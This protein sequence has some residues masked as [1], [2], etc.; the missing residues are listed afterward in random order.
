MN[1]NSNS[2][3]NVTNIL[4]P[5]DIREFPKKEIN[6]SD[7][8]INYKYNKHTVNTFRDHANVYPKK[9]TA[10]ESSI[11]FYGK[12]NIENQR[13]L[14]ESRN[15]LTNINHKVS[16]QDNTRKELFRNKRYESNVKEG[17]SRSFSKSH[18]NNV[19]ITDNEINEED[20]IQKTY[21][22]PVKEYGIS[23]REKNRGNYMKVRKDLSIDNRVFNTMILREKYKPKN[24]IEQFIVNNSKSERGGTK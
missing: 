14:R 15:K 20:F 13:Q 1:P 21:Y 6:M 16:Q 8:N 17:R 11:T 4:E 2:E 9:L 10:S 19:E 5:E 12:K 3:P 24:L 23:R 22:E 7:N 18:N